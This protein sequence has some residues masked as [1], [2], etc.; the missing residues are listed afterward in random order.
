MSGLPQ[1]ADISGPGRH[2]AFV[3]IADMRPVSSKSWF[4]FSSIEQE[5]L[6]HDTTGMSSNEWTAQWMRQSK[7]LAQMVSFGKQVL[8]QMQPAQ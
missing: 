1:T 4:L 6:R 8:R 5:W 7:Q 3:P 2:F